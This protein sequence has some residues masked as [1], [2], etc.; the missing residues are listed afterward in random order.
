MHAYTYIINFNRPFLDVKSTPGLI[1]GVYLFS[2]QS[3]DR[4]LAHLRLT[5]LQEATYLH[6]LGLTLHAHLMS[7]GVA[8]RQW[9]MHGGYGGSASTQ[10]YYR[11]PSKV[12]KVAFALAYRR[13]STKRSRPRLPRKSSDSDCT[14][15][16][17]RRQHVRWAPAC[18]RS[19]LGQRS[20]PP[21]RRSYRTSRICAAC[22]PG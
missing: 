15:I 12:P 17:S 4:R 3:L 8:R 7:V 13:T 1:G 2:K 21:R 16:Q 18:R 9:P 14:L 6:V 20:E 10:K 11:S 5:V 19:R 22:A